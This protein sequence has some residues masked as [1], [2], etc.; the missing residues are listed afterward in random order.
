[1]K[2]TIESSLPYVAEIEGLSP[3]A[4]A[5]LYAKDAEL[6]RRKAADAAK[7]QRMRAARTAR[8]EAQV[9]DAIQAKRSRLEKEPRCAWTSILLEHYFTK[10]GI[11][12]PDEEVVRRVVK[13]FDGF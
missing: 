8:I 12:A 6:A 2:T 10:R 1:M 9:L 4:Q 13:S 11:K 7:A 3:G 5:Y